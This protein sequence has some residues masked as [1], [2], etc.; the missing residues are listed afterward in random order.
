MRPSFPEIL[1]SAKLST[2]ISGSCELSASRTTGFVIQSQKKIMAWAAFKVGQKAEEFD[3]WD[4]Q[5]CE[6]RK[7]TASKKRE[8]VS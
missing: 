1:G 3:W 5:V 6:D 2:I 4:E 8:T 7:G